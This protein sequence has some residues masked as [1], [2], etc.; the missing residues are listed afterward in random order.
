MDAAN[1][2][3]F[4]NVDN[5]RLRGVTNINGVPTDYAEKEKDENE[6][7]NPSFDESSI[8]DSQNTT[9]ELQTKAEQV[10]GGSQNTTGLD[11]NQQSYDDSSIVSSQT[12]TSFRRKRGRKKKQAAS[13]D[14]PLRRSLRTGRSIPQHAKMWEEIEQ[15]S[16]NNAQTEME[17]KM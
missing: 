8:A 16:Q 5:K 10:A 14:Q 11:Q 4:L 3:K 1:S 2:T 13:S 15:Q 17:K 12:D 6:D 9:T 7:L